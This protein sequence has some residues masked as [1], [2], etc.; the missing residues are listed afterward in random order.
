[1]T[2]G[3]RC[4]RAGNLLVASYPVA[5]VIPLRPLLAPDTSATCDT[6]LPPPSALRYGHVHVGLTIHDWGVSFGNGLHNS[7]DDLNGVQV[8]ILNRAQNN[9]APFQ[10]LPVLNVHL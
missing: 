2:V 9:R 8:G 6:T 7:A 4:L 1:M 3:L 5:S 10:I